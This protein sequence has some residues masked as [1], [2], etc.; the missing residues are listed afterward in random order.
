[1]NQAAKH[2]LYSRMAVARVA[3]SKSSCLAAARVANVSAAAPVVPAAATTVADMAACATVTAA[4]SVGH[5][6]QGQEL[7]RLV[8]QRLVDLPG[9]LGPCVMLALAGARTALA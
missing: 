7:L 4:T 1:M 3:N 6:P 2:K 8:P 5:P 9:A